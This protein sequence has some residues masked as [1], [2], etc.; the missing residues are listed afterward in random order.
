M[1]GYQYS[2]LF[3]R[4]AFQNKKIIIIMGRTNLC[5]VSG[6]M[7]RGEEKKKDINKHQTTMR[8]TCLI[9][10]FLQVRTFQRGPVLERRKS[11]RS[12]SWRQHV[13]Q[14]YRRCLAKYK[15]RP[16]SRLSLSSYFIPFVTGTRTE[17]QRRLQ[18]AHQRAPTDCGPTDTLDVGINF[19]V[20]NVEKATTKWGK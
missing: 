19:F 4:D 5:G 2:D 11:A 13:R 15:N 10:N 14:E 17:L 12:K 6:R 7:L 3:D 8:F 9:I 16:L 20:E 18:W 1:L